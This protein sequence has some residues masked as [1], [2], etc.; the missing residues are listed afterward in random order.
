MQFIQCDN[1]IW[2]DFIGKTNSLLE[3]INGK[4]IIIWGYKFAGWFIENYLKI[5]NH[6]V[7]MII[8]DDPNINNKLNIMRSYELNTFKKSEAAIL[9]TFA[10]EEV[11]SRILTDLDFEEN[12][13]FFYLKELLNISGKSQLSY[14][15]FLE[16]NM[17]MDIVSSIVNDDI[18]KP[19]EDSTYYSA[20][21]DYSLASVLSEFHFSKHDKVFDFGCGKGAALFLFNL[22]GVDSNN[23]G[24]VEYDERVYK[25]AK[26]NFERAHY[27]TSNLYRNDAALLQTELDNFNIFYMY[28][29]FVGKTFEKVI[30]N[31]ETSYKRNNRKIILIYANPICHDYLD[32]SSIFVHSR[33]IHMEV[34]L[35]YA[36]IY[37]IE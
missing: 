25:I 2:N 32:N 11:S 14:Y 23:L 6:E 20:G 12:R 29:P 4:K 1:N 16:S 24:G 31:I 3:K 9:I 30:Q 8:D 35:R 21:F 33:K 5:N 34:G 19:N 15:G 28:N 26:Q 36:N 7:Y 18:N 37:I 17:K 22:F 10:R 13:D 27:S